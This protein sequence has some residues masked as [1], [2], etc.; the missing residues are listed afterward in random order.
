MLH[1]DGFVIVVVVAVDFSTRLEVYELKIAVNW[2]RTFYKVNFYRR[3][4]ATCILVVYE[5]VSICQ[6]L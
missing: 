5:H 3:S 6:F 2:K 1:N 4:F